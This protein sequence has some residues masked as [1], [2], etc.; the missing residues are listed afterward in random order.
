MSNCRAKGLT[1]WSPVA[2]SY[3]HRLNIQ[4]YHILPTEVHLCVLYTSEQQATFAVHSINWLVFRSVSKI[5]KSDY[6]LR[7]V[8]PSVFPHGTTKLVLD[9]FLWNLI[10]C[11]ENSRFNTIWQNSVWF[12]WRPIYINDTSLNSSADRSCRMIQTTN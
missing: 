8:C 9:W 1:F 10:I 6:Y 11:G 2:T 7:H 4:K 12:T 5:A 3:A